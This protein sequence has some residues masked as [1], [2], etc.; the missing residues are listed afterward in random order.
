LFSGFLGGQGATSFS[1]ALFGGVGA[2]GPVQGFFPGFGSALAGGSGALAAAG[3][4][5]LLGALGG[6]LFGSDPT[7]TGAGSAIGSAIGTAIL[8][9]IGTVVGGLLGG[10]IGGI[11][12]KDD[13]L[14]P[15]VQIVGNNVV[16]DVAGYGTSDQ[17]F[18]TMLGGSNI[19][20]AQEI[21][22]GV[23]SRITD[24]ITQFDNAIGSFLT[25][26]QL[27]IVQRD[28]ANFG[29]EY[30]GEMINI[31][32][33]LEDRFARIVTELT[34]HS[35]PT[36]EEFLSTIEGFEE[37]GRAFE[38]YVRAFN[39]LQAT[40]TDFVSSN[41][42]QEVEEALNP[43]AE[44]LEAA[45]ERTRW[46]MRELFANFD[47]TSEVAPEKMM[48]INTIIQERYEAE[49]V[50]LRQVAE[51]V[52][53]ITQSIQSQREQIQNALRG[54]DTRS[55][56]EIIADVEQ[57]IA[58]IGDADTPQ[59]VAALVDQAQRSIGAAFNIANSEDGNASMF[60]QLLALLDVLEAASLGRLDTLAQDVIEEGDALRA[61][62]Q[63]F[64]EEYGIA[65]EPT[66][67]AVQDVGQAVVN[68]TADLID[69][70]ARTREEIRQV[71]NAVNELTQV[72]QANGGRLD[73]VSV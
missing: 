53:A 52:N 44:T 72:V 33:M 69:D 24:A 20:N 66:T 39:A 71:S 16:G 26:D 68:Q 13:T 54:P 48:E 12:G 70:N 8:P 60:R 34:K 22:D 73:F 63:L 11:I 58:A 4:W 65:L 49:L 37:Q 55:F 32:T 18:E 45:L 46:K 15:A 35:I 5:G 23:L 41:P 25:Q 19:T 21:D 10:I 61:E 42:A 62:A 7:I 28:L 56:S 64:A 6:A 59:G 31:T 17:F 27:G 38:R 67:Q 14:P 50:Y 36:L 40:L 1:S 51:L 29:N 2:N 9:G 3:V 57:F 47:P 30:V 43:I